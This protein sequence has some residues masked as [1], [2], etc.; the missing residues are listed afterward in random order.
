[1]PKPTLLIPPVPELDVKSA[2]LELK[3]FTLYRFS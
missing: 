3:K 1:M 2:I